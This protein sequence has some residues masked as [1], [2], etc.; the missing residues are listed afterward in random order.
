LS[1]D[2]RPP[3]V[4]PATLLIGGWL[5]GGLL[6]SWPVSAVPEHD[7][8]AAVG[9]VACGSV[10]D[11]PAWYWRSDAA[12]D[13]ALATQRRRSVVFLLGAPVAAV[14]FATVSARRRDRQTR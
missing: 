10:F 12:C 3:R 1:D 9:P 7:F 5:V 6:G 13:D 2:F 8:G 11:D 14:A 4:T